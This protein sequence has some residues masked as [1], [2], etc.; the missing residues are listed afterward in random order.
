MK[1]ETFTDIEHSFRRKK[2]KREG[3]LEIMD[4]GRAIFQYTPVRQPSGKVGLKPRAA[5]RTGRYLHLYALRTPV[6]GYAV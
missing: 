4:A 2:T 1:Q 6:S 3:F 5:W